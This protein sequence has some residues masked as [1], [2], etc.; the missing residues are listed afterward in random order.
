MGLV[1]RCVGLEYGCLGMVTSSGHK[2]RF[3]YAFG[4]YAVRAILSSCNRDA[5]EMHG[6]ST[7]PHG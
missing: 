1:L 6:G 3:E 5:K 7:D 2:A 4:V